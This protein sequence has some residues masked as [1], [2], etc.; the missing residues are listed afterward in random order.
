[1]KRWFVL[2]RYWKAVRTGSVEKMFEALRLPQDYVETMTM[3]DLTNAYLV[4]IH[5]LK[6]KR[7]TDRPKAAS[8]GTDTSSIPESGEQE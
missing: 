8:M 5:D 2:F 6:K 1:M 7:P 3:D 4:R